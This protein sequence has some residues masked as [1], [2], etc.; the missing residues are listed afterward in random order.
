MV[1]S[2]SRGGHIKARADE[3][4]GPETLVGSVE[5]ITFH[6]ADTGFAVLE[7]KARGR[8]HLVAL[9]GHAPTIGAG[10]YI[11]AVGLWFTDRTHGLQFEADTLTMTPIARYLGSGMVRG[12]GPKLAE[13]IVLLFGVETFEIIE[14]DLY[15]LKDV[16]G[17]S[18]FRAGRIAAGWAERKAVRDIMVFLRGHGVST[19]RAVRIFK[20]YGHDAIIIMTEDPYRL[21]RDIRGIG[22]RSADAIAMRLGLTKES[23]LPVEELN[24]LAVTLLEVAETPIR[25]A[26]E[27][28]LAGCDVILDRIETC[29]Y[30]ACTERNA[31]SPSG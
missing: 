25:I 12:I 16:P 8:R 6:N 27:G 1:S 19:S 24:R 11:H 30:A 18:I 4:P 9:V 28:E 2:P 20:T 21:A 26:I 22:L 29:S 23:T 5:R 7:V 17:I 14:A 13:R 31:I 3:G 15:R 10:E